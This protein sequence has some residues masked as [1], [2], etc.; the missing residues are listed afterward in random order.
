MSDETVKISFLGVD[1]RSKSAYEFFFNSL[2]KIQCEIVNENSQSQICLID[3]DA[4]NIQEKYEKFQQEYPDQFILLLSLKEHACQSVR[5]FFLKKPVKKDALQASLNKIC[6][7]MSGKNIEL[8][9]KIKKIQEE[10]STFNKF[11]EATQKVKVNLD[12]DKVKLNKV[13][14]Q[15][16]SHDNTTVVPIKPVIKP[17]PKVVTSNAGKLIK[18]SNDKDFVGEQADI[19]IRDP[20]QLKKIYYEPKK[21][22]QSIVEKV[23]IKSRETDSIIQLNVLNHVFYFDYHEQTVYSTVGPG[24]IRPLCLIPHDNNISFKAKDA[25][26]RTELHEII[27]SNKNKTTKKTLEKQSWNMESFMWLITLWSSRG[28]LPEGTGLSDPVYLIQWPNLTRLDSVPHA[29]RISALLYDKPHTLIE[30]AQQLGIE[31]R[32]VFAFYSA[33][34]SIGLADISR[35]QLE[36]KGNQELDVKPYAPQKNKSPSNS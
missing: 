12:K 26:F 20:A 19:D 14:D 33:C 9:P 30:T 23:C 25:S 22:L 3:K 29:V 24:I 18:I 15:A 16:I 21:F 32:Y 8:A 10:I 11:S 31:Q 4:Y 36:R 2:D 27:Q 6:Y 13:K 34:K 1:E 17:K 7:L 35:R 28:R 5:E